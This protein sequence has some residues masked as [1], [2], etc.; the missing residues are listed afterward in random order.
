MACLI[1]QWIRPPDKIIC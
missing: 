1:K